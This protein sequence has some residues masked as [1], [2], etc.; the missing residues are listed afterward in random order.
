MRQQDPF[1]DQLLQKMRTL[2]EIRRFAL[3]R[4]QGTH[5]GFHAPKGFVQDDRLHTATHL[6]DVATGAESVS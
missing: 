2:F 3:K 6:V 4:T 1:V 5:T